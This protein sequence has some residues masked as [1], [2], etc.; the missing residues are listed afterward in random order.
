[1]IVQFLV[2]LCYSVVEYYFVTDRCG[3]PVELWEE[4][5]FRLTSVRDFIPPTHFRLKWRHSAYTPTYGTGTR[6]PNH[7]PEEES[8]TTTLICLHLTTPRLRRTDLG[9]LPTINKNIT[10]SEWACIEDHRAGFVSP[11]QS[12]H[13][14]PEVEPDTTPLWYQYTDSNVGS[15]H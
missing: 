8:T 14:Y 4:E 11:P 1:M 10:P 9:R 6:H 13:E 3:L 12:E 5:N 15:R 7:Q 2:T